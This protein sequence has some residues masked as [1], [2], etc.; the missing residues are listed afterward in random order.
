MSFPIKAVVFDWAGTMVDFGCVAPVHALVEVFAA[1]GVEITPAEARA[2][3]GRAK[4]DHLRGILG[5]PDVAERWLSTKGQAWDEDDVARI[6]AA[7]EPAMAEAATR[8]AT[9]IPGAAKVVE[10]LRSL[11]VGIGS[12]TGYTPAMMAGI[13]SAAKAQGYEP[14]VVICAGDTPSGRPAPLMTWAALIQLNAYP[15]GL[16]VKVDDAPVGIEEG[17]AAGCWTVGIAGSGNEIG[18]ERE[19]YLALPEDERAELLASAGQVLRDAGA[20][21]VIE[22][23]SQLMPVIQDIADR[24]AAD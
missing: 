17:K 21:Y 6:Y 15:A 2:D 4:M 12:G 7:L 23:I 18:L 13:R 11:G 22:D 14:D 10:E 3:M 19:D 20:D 16:C 24:L 5:N 8:S 9:L 1:E